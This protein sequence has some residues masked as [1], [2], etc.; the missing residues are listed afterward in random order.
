MRELG[1][2]ADDFPYDYMDQTIW[3]ENKDAMRSQINYSVRRPPHAEEEEDD[4][5]S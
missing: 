2:L 4:V 5:E 3:F 1:L